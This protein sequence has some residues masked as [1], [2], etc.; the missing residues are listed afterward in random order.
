MA[1]ARVTGCNQS[2]RGSG[3][4]VA[5]DRKKDLWLVSPCQSRRHSGS[6]GPS[7]ADSC[8]TAMRDTR[9]AEGLERLFRS[10]SGGDRLWR[11]GSEVQAAV[12][13][14]RE[15]GLEISVRGGGH[16]LGYGTWEDAPVID[17]SPMKAIEADA[18]ARTCRA[19]PGLTWGEFDAAT[20]AQGLAVT[21]GRVTSTGVASLT[22]GSGWARA[23]L[24]ADRR[25]PPLRGGDD[26]RR[27]LSDGEPLR[28][29]GP[30]LG[31]AGWERQFRDRHR[32]HLPAGPD[33][34]RHLWRYARLPA[35]AG[36]RGA[37]VPQR[38]HGRRAGRP[39]RRSGVRERP[40]SEPFVP[41]EMHFAPTVG[42]MVCR[43]GE[44]EEGERRSESPDSGAPG[45]LT[46]REGNGS[47]VADSPGG[48]GH[49]WLIPSSARSIVWAANG[50]QRFGRGRRRDRLGA[51]RRDGGRRA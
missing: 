13:F 5:R 21:G 27:A 28:Q 34:A 25:Q 7:A 26:R 9:S 14:A 4:R 18:A 2:W 39:R 10:P 33:R 23:A 19:Q 50:R 32:V 47:R 15:Q 45:C 35:R 40:P 38:L 36:A 3:I 37:A 44:I 24:R 30:V 51:T 6:P 17:L 42:V 29:P 16:G 22:L 46:A 31:P 43:T 12:A 41:Q 20:Q 48:I 1:R 8:G 49:V 11:S